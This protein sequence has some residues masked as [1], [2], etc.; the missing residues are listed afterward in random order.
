MSSSTATTMITVNISVD[1]MPSMA[2]CSTV[3]WISSLEVMEVSASVGFISSMESAT[4][5]MS[6]TGPT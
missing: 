5:P 6:L 4:P 1:W 2:S 3:F